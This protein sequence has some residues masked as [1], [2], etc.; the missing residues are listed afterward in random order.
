MLAIMRRH[1]GIDYAAPVGVPVTTAARGEI[2]EA[3]RNGEFGN[4]VLVRHRDGVETEYAQLS[5]FAPGMA[6][7]RCVGDGEVI[8]YVGNTGMS[9]GPH[10]HMGLRINGSLVDPAPYIQGVAPGQP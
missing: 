9:T 2:V 8:G 7:G 3:R 4:Y 6:P 10:L 5:K 1:E